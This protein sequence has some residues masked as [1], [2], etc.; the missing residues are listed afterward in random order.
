MSRG[1]LRP[2]GPLT[3]NAISDTLLLIGED[4]TD[5]VIRT[6]NAKQRLQVYDW[7]IRTHLRASDNIIAVPSKPACLRKATP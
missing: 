6:W 7:A 4:T 5:E 1:K 3:I 2:R